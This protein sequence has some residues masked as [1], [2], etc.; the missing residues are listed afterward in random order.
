MKVK[1]NVLERITLIGLLPSEENYLTYK[2][3]TTLKMELSFS[4]V[5]W[6]KCGMSS[7]PD[8]RTRWTDGKPVK[9]VEIPDVIMDMIKVKLESLETKKKINADNVTLYERLILDK[10]PTKK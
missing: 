3:I 5:E 9:A 8:G 10:T 6:K 7:L 4:P 1:L 2:M